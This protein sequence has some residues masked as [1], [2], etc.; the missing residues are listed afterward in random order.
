MVAFMPLVS[1]LMPV[2]NS[3]AFVGAAIESILAQTFTDFEL[4]IVDDASQDG[5]ADVIRSYAR[6]DERIRFFPLELN[7][8][9][10]DSRNQ[11]MALARGKYI[12]AMDSDDVSLPER[13]RKQVQ[14]LEANPH[15]GALGAR[16]R[17][18][19]QD[20]K[21]L[22]DQLTPLSHPLIVLNMFI[23]GGFILQST[24]VTRREIV[25]S[26][27]GYEPG[28]RKYDDLELHSRLLAESRIRYAN[29][30]DILVLYRRHAG[31]V[32][33]RADL[34]KQ[35]PPYQDPTGKMLDSLWNRAPADTLSR[36]ARMYR[37]QKLSWPQ[38]R[39]ARRDLKRLIESMD[40]A[41]WIDAGD[42]PQ[43]LTEVDR[44]LEQTTPRLWQMFCHW[45]R[46]H[47]GRSL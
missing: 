24:L 22:R 5:S 34:A 38:R 25:S 9:Q 14:Y 15:I 47:F 26:I 35:S 23:G 6:R 8:G 45:R 44:R 10:A 27:G 4:V 41:G 30:P 46:H 40:D 1:V 21:P 33:V 2:F 12:A 29:L 39:L 32:S 18:V 19:D 36:F 7:V 42:R 43:L 16:F 20:L 31:S 13:L 28:R 17:E 37:G 11:A 3:E